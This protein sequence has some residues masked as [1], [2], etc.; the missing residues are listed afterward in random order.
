MIFVTISDTVLHSLRLI[1]FS[2][3]YNKQIKTVK[4][5][6]QHGGGVKCDVASE[7]IELH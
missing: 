1:L 2:V 7:I 4:H 6:E 5:Y 3:S